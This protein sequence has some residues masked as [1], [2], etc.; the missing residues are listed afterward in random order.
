MSRCMSPH[1]GPYSIVSHPPKIAAGWD[2]LGRGG[3]W[4]SPPLR[5]VVLILGFGSL[6]QHFDDF[7]KRAPKNFYLAGA[8]SPY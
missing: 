4:A 1:G 8:G 2:S 5:V 3:A 6:A 7:R